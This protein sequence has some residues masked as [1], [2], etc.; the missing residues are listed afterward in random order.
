MKKLFALTLSLCLCLGLLASCSKKPAEGEQ[1]GGNKTEEKIIKVAASPAPHAGI[2]AVAK[3]ILKE[4]GIT[5]EIV[6]MN[7]YK[8]PNLATESGDVMANYFQHIAYLDNTNKTEGTHLVNVAE[9]HYEPYGLYPGKTASVDA[10]KPGATI[11]V[12]NDTSNQARA[13]SLLETQGLIKMKEGVGLEGSILDIVE[14]KLNLNIQEM[15][16]AQLPAALPTVDMAVINGN[17]A[18]DAGLSVAKDAIAVEKASDSDTS[19]VYANVLVVKEGN[20]NNELVLALKKA[21]Q[22]DEVREYIQTTY[23]DGSVVPLF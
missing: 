5:L 12:T 11:L 15:E 7:D 18:I 8:Q 16:A 4:E 17:Y 21:L 3:E 14:N 1:T 9:I 10:L 2:L 23:A 6:E 13:L 19:A 22:S 20:E